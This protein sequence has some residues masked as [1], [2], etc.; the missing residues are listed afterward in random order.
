MKA[1]SIIGRDHA[2]ATYR[3]ADDPRGPSGG[4]VARILFLRQPDGSAAPFWPLYDY[5]SA[6]SH[7]SQTWQEVLVRSVGLFWDYCQSHDGAGIWIAGAPRDSRDL[8]VAFTQA[9]LSGTIDRA[10]ADPL[11]L[12]WPPQPAQLVRRFV[13]SISGF[14]RWLRT[15][16]NSQDAADVPPAKPPVGELLEHGQGATTSTALL[17]LLRGVRW[18]LESA[19]AMALRAGDGVRFNDGNPLSFPPSQLERLI[20]EGFRRG[21]GRAD[22]WDDYDVRSMMIVI[23]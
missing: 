4:A 18:G 2:A 8:M 1:F 22:T 20:W 14:H 3:V 10:G 5:V 21:C 23:L 17:G 11:D 9:L 12:Y 19:T 7:L 6:H 16:Q 15:S 13:R